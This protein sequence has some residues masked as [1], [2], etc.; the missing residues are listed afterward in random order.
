MTVT[1][2]GGKGW[3]VFLAVIKGPASRTPRARPSPLWVR[4]QTVRGSHHFRGSRTDP[5]GEGPRAGAGPGPPCF[6]PRLAARPTHLGGSQPLPHLLHQEG[7]QAAA[8]GAEKLGAR[9]RPGAGTSGNHRHGS[10][11]SRGLGC[12]RR[13][14]EV[15]EAARRGRRAGCSQ[16]RTRPEGPRKV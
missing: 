12:A 6:L 9:C 16:G 15:P 1:C 4:G 11:G 7:L 5:S 10:S 13:G 8:R 14:P 3:R 2:V